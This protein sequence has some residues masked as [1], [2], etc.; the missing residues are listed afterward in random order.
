[1]MPLNPTCK[2]GDLEIP[3]VTIPARNYLHI[4]FIVNRN[5]SSAH[6]ESGYNI[7]I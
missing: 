3:I 6:E 7:N 5:L 1:M 2:P 4:F